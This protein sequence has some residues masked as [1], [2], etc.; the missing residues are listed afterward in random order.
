[1]GSSGGHLT[2]LLWLR[3]WW[4]PHER[5]WVCLRAADS[6]AALAGESVTWGYGPTNRS[7]VN[8]VRNTGLAY[9]VLRRER[10]DVLVS[11][12]AGLAVP[13]F[14]VGRA[15]GIPLVYIEVV[16]RVETPSWTG[17]LV[18]PWCDA[19]VVQDARQLAFY[20][21]AHLLGPIR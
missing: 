16:D 11:C 2:P 21:T 7:G 8:A 13:F 5:F 20:P 4:E 14:A 3:S 10:P 18:S 19:V 17:K 1:M 12:G 9:R 6:E 15:L